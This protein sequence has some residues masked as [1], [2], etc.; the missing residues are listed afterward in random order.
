MANVRITYTRFYPVGNKPLDN[1]IIEWI[2]SDISEDLKSGWEIF[3]NV[4]N[5]SNYFDLIFNS[6]SVVDFDIF[7]SEAVIENFHIWVRVADEGGDRDLIAFSS[8]T[9][10]P[11]GKQTINN[12]IMRSYGN[13]FNNFDYIKKCLYRINHLSIELND[14]DEIPIKD[15]FYYPDNWQVE[16]KPKNNVW[17]YQ[18]D[19]H[20]Y[21]S[22]YRI[23]NHKLYGGKST[24]LDYYSE[25]KGVGD[26]NK[27]FHCDA[28]FYINEKFLNLVYKWTKESGYPRIN[29]KIRNLKIWFNDKV[30]HEWKWSDEENRW[31]E[32]C[33]TDWSNI[34]D[35][36]YIRFME[37]YK[38]ET[39]ANTG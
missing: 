8:P 12:S 14:N 23:F 31:I 20:Y 2:L 15:L 37:Y 22:S 30:K 19:A 16:Y 18:L 3:Y 33:S 32:S 29:E 25:F 26:N 5:E 28:K 6:K 9:Y 21:K 1:K 7:K 11:I 27:I 17:H 39:I 10:K 35:E 38:K 24:N 34:S 36:E 13:R 4:N